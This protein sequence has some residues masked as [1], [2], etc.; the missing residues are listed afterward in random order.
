M[1]VEDVKET[2][3]N[4][5]GI[6]VAEV[7]EI[8]DEDVTIL[9]EQVVSAKVEDETLDQFDTNSLS[10]QEVIA[11]FSKGDGGQAGVSIETSATYNKNKFMKKFNSKY[12]HEDKIKPAKPTMSCKYFMRAIHLTDD[13]VSSF[14]TFPVESDIGK[15][16]KKKKKDKM[17]VFVNGQVIDVDDEDQDDDAQEEEKINPLP[18]IFQA[19][20]DDRDQTCNKIL[21]G[22]RID[23]SQRS[24][25]S[26]SSIDDYKR[27]VLACIDQDLFSEMRTAKE[28][29]GNTEIQ[30]YEGIVTDFNPVEEE[31]KTHVSV[32]VT[33]DIDNF[34]LSFGQKIMMSIESGE[35]TVKDTLKIFANVYGIEVKE[36]DNESAQVTHCLHVYFLPFHTESL[37]DKKCSIRGLCHLNHLFLQAK[38]VLSLEKHRLHQEFLNPILKSVASG[39]ELT[40]SERFKDRYGRSNFFFY[41]DCIQK[42]IDTLA[43]NQED[44]S[45]ICIIDDP[46]VSNVEDLVIDAVKYIVMTQE[47]FL[48]DKSSKYQ[49]IVTGPDDEVLF[50]AADYLS[51]IAG[52]V[53]YVSAKSG[54]PT[55]K[56]IHKKLE[57]LIE[58]LPDNHEQ[59]TIGKEVLESIAK[60][61]NFK[62]I[63][64]FSFEDEARYAL[65]R[66]SHIL[67]G[68]ITDL[69]ND[70]LVNRIL[71]DKTY[72]AAIVHDSSSLKEHELL[73]LQ[74]FD[75]KKLV[76]LNVM[77]RTLDDNNVAQRLIRSFE[78]HPNRKTLG[79][80][81]PVI[82]AFLSEEE[83][84]QFD[85]RWSQ[86]Y[87]QNNSEYTRGHDNR[88]RQPYY[89][90]DRGNRGHWN[91]DRGSQRGSWRGHPSRGRG[92]PNYAQRDE[93]S[94][95]H[96]DDR[97]WIRKNRGGFSNVSDNNHS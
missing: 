38:T 3:A 59:K 70:P 5:D 35:G 25:S 97:P 50:K 11:L 93:Y 42:I 73:S 2:Q 34:D 28:K 77:G 23:C 7:Y 65:M 8:F 58:S 10:I 66:E 1:S 60:D 94:R 15:K 51:Q 89:R 30:E 22:Q 46:K 83:K 79:A 16:S 57:S 27:T 45:S 64:R 84:P 49:I 29:I 6:V 74:L 56:A 4:E 75:I 69:F 37:L 80:S 76:L 48:E 63:S 86:P 13:P 53:Y 19:Y 17:T 95:L 31:K 18:V 82:S 44:I 26:F 96:S 88:G 92:A 36:V 32:D 72:D 14:L 24:L 41:S 91:N 52:N 67:V 20:M 81:S 68:N 47:D 21:E 85:Q 90:N 61:A 71:E 40:F 54:I 62:S 33:H 9:N 12:L 39:I 43:T 78:S 55:Q 87:R